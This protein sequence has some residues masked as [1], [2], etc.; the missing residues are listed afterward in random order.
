MD[1]PTKTRADAA[2]RVTLAR[3]G[4]LANRPSEA[5]LIALH[6]YITEWARNVERELTKV[7]LEQGGEI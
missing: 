5:Y 7:Q 4:S 3:L 2:Q 1:I 6:R